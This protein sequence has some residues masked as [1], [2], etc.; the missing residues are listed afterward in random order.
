M[1]DPVEILTTVIALLITITMHEL[2]HGAMAYAMG[3]TTARDQGRLTLNPLAH[4]DPL[5]TL[6]MIFF[7]FGWAKPVP[8]NPLRFRNRTLGMILV[9]LAGALMNL[10][11]ALIAAFILAH[12]APQNAGLNAVLIL[13]FQYN[14]FF[15]VFNLMPFPPLDGSKIILSL[16]PH[17]IGRKIYAYERYFYMVLVIL[18]V[19][20]I[21]SRFLVPVASAIMQGI[22]LLVY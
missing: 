19:T 14:V 12:F 8:I 16:L 18:L 1:F 17:S 15:A 22:L 10:T 7:R 6:S 21:L 3:D 9:S 4:L 5:G 20:G 2:A 13:L 11:I